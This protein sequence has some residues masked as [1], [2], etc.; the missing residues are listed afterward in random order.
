MPQ[1]AVPA[2]NTKHRCG[3]ETQWRD[4]HNLRRNLRT[5]ELE[6][7]SGMG[8]SYGGKEGG[9]VNMPGSLTPSKV[10]PLLYL[11]P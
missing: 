1:Q 5:S 9:H 8:L 3:M 2:W 6:W 11:N 10:L 7:N 4:Q